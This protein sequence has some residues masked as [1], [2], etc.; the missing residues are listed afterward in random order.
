MAISHYPRKKIE[1]LQKLGVNTI[2]PHWMGLFRTPGATSDVSRI[3]FRLRRYPMKR[4]TL[5]GLFIAAAFVASPV[6]AAEDLC[7]GNIKKIEN[8]QA[9]SSAATADGGVD[10][11]ASIA[12]AKKEQAAGDKKGCITTTTKTLSDIAKSK[13]GGAAGN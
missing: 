4:T 9:T 12:A 13:K 8:E 2:K 10:Y 11:K 6:F 3:I 7:A 1:P 5:T